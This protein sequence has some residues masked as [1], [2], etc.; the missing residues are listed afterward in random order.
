MN[1]ELFITAVG[2]APGPGKPM[3]KSD[4]DPSDGA[5]AGM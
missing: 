3:R 2:L 1:R 5:D 4:G